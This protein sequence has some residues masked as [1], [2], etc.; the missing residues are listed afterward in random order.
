MPDA[1]W[2]VNG[3]PP[4]S[5][6]DSYARPGSD[7]VCLISTRQRQRA[8]A[9]RSSSR[10]SP[11]AI[12]AAPFPTTFKTTV[13][14]QCP[15]RR[16]RAIVRTTALEGQQTSIS[17]AAPQSTST[18]THFLRSCSQHRFKHEGRWR[19]QISTDPTHPPGTIV[20]VSPTGHVYLSYPHRY[21][22]PP[23]HPP[24]QPGS[25]TQPG[26]SETPGHTGADGSSQP[27]TADQ[28]H[29]SKTRIDDD[30]GEP[31]F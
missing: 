4:D 12:I 30:P 23:K 3:Y 26:H 13:F 18:I 16:F 27:G 5:S 14:S 17:H 28:A 20:I 8:P 9:H 1:A 6:R 22:L 31:P 25:T 2:A 15:S 29:P 24:G 10:S 19:H 21:D 11:D 7:A